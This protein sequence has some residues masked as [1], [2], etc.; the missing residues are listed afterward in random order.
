MGADFALLP[1]AAGGTR[2]QRRTPGDYQVLLY[3]GGTRAAGEALVQHVRTHFGTRRVDH[4]VNSH[5]DGDHASGLAV[6]LEQL[7]VQRLWMHRPWAH[8]PVMLGIAANGYQTRRM[9][10]QAIGRMG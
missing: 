3:D 6:V 7:D 10:L 5:P 8:S 1:I 9:I 4:V 2:T